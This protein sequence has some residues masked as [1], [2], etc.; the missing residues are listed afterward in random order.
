MPQPHDNDIPGLLLANKKFLNKIIE[1]KAVEG[2]V[3]RGMVSMPQKDRIA[4]SGQQLIARKLSRNLSLEIT[5]TFI[6]YNNVTTP[7]PNNDIIALQSGGRFKI[8]KCMSLDLEFDY[9]PSTEIGS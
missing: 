8:R 9:L 5:P 4:Y 1:L 6:H 7:G 2:E 3:K